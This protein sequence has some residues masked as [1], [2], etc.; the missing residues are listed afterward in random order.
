MK[1]GTRRRIKA[2]QRLHPGGA[3]ALFLPFGATFAQNPPDDAPT[4][5][6]TVEVTGSHIP[7]VQF[8]TSQPLLVLD[9]SDLQRSGLS[10]VGE[11]LQQL[12]Q[13]VSDVNSD[14]QAEFNNG[15]TRVDLRN[16]GANRTLVLLNGHR[17]VTALDGAV[18]V[19]SIPLPIVDRIEVLTDGA[20]AIYG[21]DA[22]AGVVNIITRNS[23]EGVEASA[24]Y[25]T[26]DHGDGERRAADITWGREGARGGVSVN[27][28]Y[29][30]QQP[31]WAGDRAISAVPTYGLPAND[32]FAG[33][34]LTTPNGLFG[35]GPGG[36]ALPDGGEGQLTWDPRLPGYRPFDWRS[37]GY[38]YA[39]ENYLRIPYERTALFA[40]GHYGITDRVGLSGTLLLHRR[41]SRLREAPTPLVQFGGSGD[42]YQYD[43]SQDNLYNGFGQPVTFFAFRP[44]NQPRR[45]EQD[46]Q[47]HYL[48][49]DLDGTLQFRSRGFDWNLNFTDARTDKDFAISGGYDLNR[50]GLGV[51]PS[52]LDATGQAR[53]GT[54][55]ATV[56]GCVPLDFLHGSTGF[57]GAMFDYIAAQG[58]VDEV[59]RLTDVAFNL[60]G[61]VADLPAG[62]LALA[63]GVEFRRESGSVVPDALLSNDALDFSGTVP[64]PVD[65][66]I[67]VGE[68]YVEFNLPLLAGKPW[69][70]SLDASLAARWSDYSTF[71]STTNHKLGL[72]WRPH[73]DWLLRASWSRGYRAPSASELFAVS[74]AFRE[75][76]LALEFLDP[77]IAPISDEVAQRC[78][79]AGVPL[80]GFNPQVGPLMRFGSNPDLEPEQAR[81]RG[82]GVVWS[83]AAL[84]GLDLTLDWWWIKLSNAIDEIPGSELP[85]LCYE[86]GVESACLQLRRDPATGVLT[87]IDARLFNYGDYRIEGYDFSVSYRWSSNWGEFNL[88]WNSVYLSRY[89]KEIP[90]GVV[91]ISTVGNYFF[92][93]PHWR[94][95][96]VLGLDWNRN[97]LGA[98]LRLRYYS[99]LDES[100]EIPA[101]ADRPDL[102]DRPDFASPVFGGA[103]EHIIDARTYAD[104]QLRWKPV[105]DMEL[106][107]G[108]NN[109]FD[110]DPPVSYYAFNSYDGAY[111]VPGRFWY[112]SWRQ[113]F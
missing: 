94:L 79:A 101:G 60:S 69:A 103:P 6:E 74:G 4:T 96:S 31:I 46:V 19:G 1:A 58:H 50:L 42:P 112:A 41:V 71:G 11:M 27:L 93:N 25:A 38:N 34:S 35:F 91:P 9:R 111:D 32:L 39:P 51:G 28:S 110:R 45:F 20:S 5:L 23:F 100:C 30:D 62:P 2:R 81:N 57:T 52:F 83:P 82:I 65:G 66:E 54:P 113:R 97:S 64:E 18:D 33:A 24:Y 3:L 43:I 84:P 16:L 8:E 92:Q 102:C 59:R 85:R 77:C 63:A 55:T 75:S 80:E 70:R 95:R 107:I 89:E 53:C 68:A 44:L 7:R 17:Y 10:N 26:S 29:A 73:P 13:H 104:L 36:A 72:S 86:Q 47:T 49:L 22:I 48:S 76:A 56:A 21:S 90:R 14:Y 88:A 61:D 99:P 78:Y 37:D 87:D 106:S 12:P 40:Q 15:E 109:A 108:V 67:R 98:T 105:A